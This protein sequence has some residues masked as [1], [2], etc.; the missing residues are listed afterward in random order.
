MALNDLEKRKLIFLKESIGA[1]TSEEALQ[2]AIE[3]E[4]TKK[5]V[6][7]FDQAFSWFN[8][9]Q[10]V[11]ENYALLIEKENHH[12]PTTSRAPQRDTH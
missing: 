2:L 1:M 8:E 3:C 12:E 6:G 10:T 5:A 11:L 4:E 9:R 7:P